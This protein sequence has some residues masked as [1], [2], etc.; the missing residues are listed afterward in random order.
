[1]LGV[2]SDSVVRQILSLTATIQ[3]YVGLSVDIN[4][5]VNSIKSPKSFGGRFHFH[6]TAM[7]LILKAAVA[8][9]QT[10]QAVTSLKFRPHLNSSCVPVACRLW[11]R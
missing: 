10:S 2:V 1:M 4:S 7:T 8:E 9:S 3:T 5:F 6:L 11:Y